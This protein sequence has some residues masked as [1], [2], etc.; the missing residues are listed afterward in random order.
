MILQV[1]CGPDRHDLYIPDDYESQDD[2]ASCASENEGPW[3][4]L[5]LKHEVE[6]VTQM[7]PA[8]QRIIHRGKTLLGDNVLLSALKI[9]NGDKLM[10]L[11]KRVEADTDETYKKLVGVERGTI[12][13]LHQKAHE[14]MEELRGLESGYLTSEQTQESLNKLGKRLRLF[15]EECMR[16]LM[17]LDAVDLTGVDTSE[18]QRN[19]NREKR[20]TLVQNVQELLRH[21]DALEDRR[22]QL[23]TERST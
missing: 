1:V 7:A 19:I 8:S 17:T 11:G 2:A 15:S 23:S 10:V 3:T 6:K 16:A 20:K 9:R 18:T 12:A 14:L 21:H 22:V 13:S 5:R 4:V